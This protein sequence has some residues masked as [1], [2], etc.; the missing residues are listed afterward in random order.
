MNIQEKVLQKIQEIVEAN[1]A[2][3][4]VQKGA[5]NTGTV[6]VMEDLDVLLVLDYNFQSS[7][8]RFQLYEH[9]IDVSNAVDYSKVKSFSMYYNKNLK[10]KMNE[11][12]DYLRVKIVNV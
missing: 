8:A 2:E 1:K 11:L 4:V 5:V 10:E 6:Y 7:Y 9:G 3:Y 12:G